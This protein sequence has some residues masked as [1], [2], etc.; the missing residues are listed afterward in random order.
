MITLNAHNAESAPPVP[1]VCPADGQPLT[2]E[3]DSSGRLTG[4]VCAA[5]HA[6]P[7]LYG[8]PRFVPEDTYANS[9]GLQWNVYRQVQLDSYSGQP[10]FAN[11]LRRIAGGSLDLFAGTTVLEA[12]CGAG[13]FTEVMLAAGAQVFAVDLS[14]AVE[15][16]RANFAGDPNHFVCQADL[17]QLPVE[18]GQFDVVVCLGVI[19]HTPDPE[20]TI[21]I[22]CDQLKPGG[23]LL[24]D[25]YPP[26]YPM[27][28]SR[29]FLRRF[30]LQRSPEFAL[31]FTNVLTRLLWPLHRLV[32][33]LTKLPRIGQRAARLRYRFME[34]SPVVD[35]HDAYAD[36]GPSLLRT[37]AVLN[38]HDLLTDTFKHLRSEEQIAAALDRNGLTGI[39]V[40]LGGNGVEA[41]AQKPLATDQQGEPA[42]G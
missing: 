4:Y 35:F 9:F 14:N 19:Q 3:T 42:N 16:N 33:Q 17:R 30:L 7:V 12:G 10:I 37:W 8:V 25:H 29:N 1:L 36:L 18:P 24:I 15:A 34:L 23:C 2:A 13:T 5:G 40:W 31:N 32:W 41:R 22:L 28:P 27:S 26:N 20:E 21:R 38:T 6:Y 39:E 11:R